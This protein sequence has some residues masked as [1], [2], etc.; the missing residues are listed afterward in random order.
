MRNRLSAVFYNLVGNI[1]ALG[2]VDGYA[3]AKS[4]AVG[5]VYSLDKRPRAVGECVEC[6]LLSLPVFFV[7]IVCRAATVL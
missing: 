2:I 6:K 3:A 7:D 1:V 4:V 5:L